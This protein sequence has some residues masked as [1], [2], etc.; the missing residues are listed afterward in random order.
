MQ[1]EAALQQAKADEVERLK[2]RSELRDALLSVNVLIDEVR[3]PHAVCTAPVHAS[4]PG[5][6]V[7]SLWRPATTVS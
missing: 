6:P 2:A 3:R 1:A 4:S 7:L 5:Q